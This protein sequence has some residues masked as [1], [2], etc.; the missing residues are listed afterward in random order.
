LLNIQHE[1]QRNKKKE[2]KKKQRIKKAR[3]P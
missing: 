3:K 2:V 1:K